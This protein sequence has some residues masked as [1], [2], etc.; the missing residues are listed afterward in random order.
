MTVDWI[1]IAAQVANFLI[2]VWL[3]K[4]FLYR[5]ILDGIDAREAEIAQRMDEARRVRDEADAKQL[6]YAG[7]LA[8]LESDQS[9]ALK[10]IDSQAQATHQKIITEAREQLQIERL[11]FVREQQAE[12]KRYAAMLQKSGAE[13]LLA[14]TRK[15]LVDLADQTFEEQIVIQAGKQID[16]S[17]RELLEAAAHASEAVVTTR[18]V[19][20]DAVRAELKHQIGARLP[21]LTLQFVAVP[22]Q[23]PG[24]ILRVGGTQVSWTVDSYVDELAAMLEHQ[25]SSTN[26]AKGLVDAH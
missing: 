10:A 14:L 8:K 24:L 6:E 21:K 12:A 4:R 15:A 7:R 16:A 26:R 5:P 22:T 2:L 20:S 1:T 9:D 11:T 19:L 13:A 25:V 23:A 17:G 3:L 18:D